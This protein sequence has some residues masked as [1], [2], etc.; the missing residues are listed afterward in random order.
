MKWFLDTECYPNYFLIVLKSLDGKLLE[1]EYDDETSFDKKQLVNIL[2][3]D[4]TIGFNSRFYDIPMIMR[5]IKENDKPTNDQ[6]KRLSDELILS[7][8]SFDIISNNFLWTPRKW[9]YIDIIRVLP[10]KCSLKMYGARIHTRK[11]Q[12]LPYDPA[13]MLTR[14]EKNILKAY[15][16]NDVDITRDLYLQI[17]DE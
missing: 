7:D 2:S 12:D 3:R 8:N 17:H 13:K 1:F 15:C 4:L 5:F 11:L 10:S 6:L 14:E 9:N 16:I